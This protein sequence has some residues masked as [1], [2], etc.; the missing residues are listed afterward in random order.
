MAKTMKVRIALVVDDDGV[1]GA[2]VLWNE[3]ATA[4]QASWDY[5]VDNWAEDAPTNPSNVG[6]LCRHIITAEVPV[7]EQQE[8]E[9]EV[10]DG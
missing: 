2:A 4:Q 10:K 5:A 1:A 9:G 3:S 7:P 8:I 6:Q